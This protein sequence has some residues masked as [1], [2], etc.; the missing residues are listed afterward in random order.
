[1]LAATLAMA[2]MNLEGPAPTNR[3][4]L[5]VHAVID[6]H[7]DQ[8]LLLLYRARTGAQ[9]STGSSNHD[10]PLAGAVV[11]ITAPNSAVMR[12]NEKARDSSDYPAGIYA[13]TPGRY[14]VV[15]A[16]G[17]TFSLYI[18]TPSGEVVSGTTTIPVVPAMST[19][20]PPDRFYRL[21]DTLRLGWPRVSGARSYEL[22]IQ[23]HVLSEY[24]TFFDSS[25]AVPGTAL[26][27]TG[28]P[29]FPAGVNVDVAV[30]AVDPNYYDYYRAQSDPFAGAAPSHLTGAVGVFGSVAPLLLAEFQVR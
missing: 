15:P 5:V 24:R 25:L 13:Y 28:D 1:M 20:V 6:T 12:A 27:I 9:S 3:S 21:R 19:K 14:G 26:T 7:A 23:R 10:E 17:G 2:C 22:V 11:T 30:S 18:R 29:I 4:Q 8:Q 16:K